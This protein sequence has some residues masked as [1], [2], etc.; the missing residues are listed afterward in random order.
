ML[1]GGSRREEG[2]FGP[3]RALRPAYPA[4]VR[5]PN[6]GRH[7]RTVLAIRQHWLSALPGS[8]A[9]AKDADNQRSGMKLAYF[10][11]AFALAALLAASTAPALSSEVGVSI[12]IGQPGFYGRVD[13][14]AFPP[15]PVI[16]RQAMV[17][18]RRPWAGAPVYLHVPPGHARHWHKHCRSYN[19]CG[20]PVYFVRNDWYQ[21]DYMPRQ[22]QR[23]RHYSRHDDHRRDARRENHRGDHGYGRR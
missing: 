22:S 11:F 5:L 23:V 16:Y 8:R 12:S 17:V 14:G 9:L 10:T 6:T 7:P 19:A 3:F 15:P 20:Q 4:G 13:L 1:R 21:R 18:E 2:G